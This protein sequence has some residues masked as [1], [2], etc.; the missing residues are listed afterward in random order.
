MQD[1]II[2]RSNAGVL[3]GQVDLELRS[4]LLLEMMRAKWEIISIP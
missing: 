2:I 4:G 3:V 1:W